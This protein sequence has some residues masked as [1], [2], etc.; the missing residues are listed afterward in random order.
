[1]FGDQGKGLTAEL[2]DGV[3][4]G[5]AVQLVVEV[6]LFGNGCGEFGIDGIETKDQTAILLLTDV[7][8]SVGKMI[9]HARFLSTNFELH[10]P[11]QHLAGKRAV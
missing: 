3:Q 11:G 5:F 9:R 7:N 8:D 1:M 4:A 10:W 2:Y 6:L